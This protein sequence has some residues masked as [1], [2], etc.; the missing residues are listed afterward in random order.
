MPYRFLSRWFAPLLAMPI[1][2]GLAC[3]D[4]QSCEEGPFGGGTCTYDGEI[5]TGDQVMLPEEQIIFRA[6]AI[7]GFGPGLPQI[8]VWTTSDPTVV[9]VENLQDNT[10]SVT[11]V[12]T[13]S[14][15]VIALINAEFVDSAQVQ[16]VVPGALRW[17][18]TFTNLPVGVY[19]A[20]GADSLVRVVTGGAS[21]LLR[22][23]TVAGAETSAA[24][25]FSAL[26]PSIGAS[27]AAFATG[28]G[29]TRRHAQGGAAD[30]TATVGSAELALA[31]AS[32]N[33]AVTLSGDSVY[34]VTS[35]GTVEWGVLLGG[36]PLTPPVIGPG[37]DVYVGWTAGG[38]DSV[39][40]VTL[41]GTPRWSVAVPGLSTG[42]PAATV[43]RLV[44]GR[45]GGL[46]ALDSA[47][48]V[49]WDRSFT[50]VN[51]LASATGATSSPVHDDIVAYVQNEDA[52]YSYALDG[53]FLW[54]ADSLG[55]GPSSGIVGAPV[56]L[57]D[58]SLLVPCL[59]A[60]GSREVCSVGQVDGALN[61]RSP[62]GNGDVAGI[63][64]ARDGTVF[65]TR[66]LSGGS[67]E[68]V[69]L[70]GR[71]APMTTGWAAEG[72]NQQHTRRR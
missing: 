44:F 28:S 67:S 22:L 10:A 38:E 63:A 31:V 49:V 71:V 62:L 48:T 57:S 17:R 27:D 6:Q 33:G 8:V 65:A 39:S 56:L 20:V 52:L 12:D 69:A 21:P 14:A 35:T 23:F 68:L 2:A 18:S 51:P 26:G 59:A 9:E 58:L 64:V 40:R 60:S 72:G 47:G 53:T 43:T 15:W 70:W 25:C 54:V 42:T 4:T 32:D 30:W 66:T 11:A 13:G 1:A 16:V 5:I 3:S 50:A 37:G 34:R 61:W 29:C 19:P 24:S 41:A 55:Y 45:P 7:Y 36:T 46:F